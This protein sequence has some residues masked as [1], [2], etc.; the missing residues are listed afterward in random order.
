[1]GLFDRMFSK[2]NCAI[3]GKELGVFGKTK[4]AD[5]AYLCKDCSGKLSPYF[6]GYS[7]ATVEDIQAQLAYREENKD[8]VR[9]F[10][11]TRTIGTDTKVYV[12]EDSGKVIITRTSP[13]NWGTSNPDVLDFSQITGCDYHIKESKTEVKKELPDGKKESYNPPR[14]DVDYDVYVTV[15]VSH[16]YVGQIEFKINQS[17]IERKVSPEYR[18]AEATAQEIKEALTGIHAEQRA[19]AAPKKPVVCPYCGATTTPDAAGNCEYCGA[20]IGGRK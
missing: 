19:A 12:D 20:F 7:T 3:C 6:H 15:Y 8:A 18:A 17:R 5:E 1:M 14:Y 2:K 13:S 4:I 10:H 11:V 9:A 16:P